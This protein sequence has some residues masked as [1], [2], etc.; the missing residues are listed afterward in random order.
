MKVDLEDFHENPYTKLVS[1]NMYDDITPIAS[2]SI[3]GPI[4]ATSDVVISRK[5]QK[6]M[7]RIRSSFSSGI[8]S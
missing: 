5:V 7:I 3:L 2:N 6:T 8:F 1:V 4:I